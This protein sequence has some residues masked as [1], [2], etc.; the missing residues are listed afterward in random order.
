M[1]YTSVETL[2][3]VE[4]IGVGEKDRRMGIGRQTEAEHAERFSRFC[5]SVLL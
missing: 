1:D 4:P 5:P 3:P 2:F